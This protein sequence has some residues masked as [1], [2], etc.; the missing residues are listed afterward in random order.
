MPRIS[1]VVPVYN[2]E[3]YLQACLESIAAQTVSDLE[4]IVVDDGSTDSSA[5]IAGR[6]AEQDPRFRVVRQPNGGLGRARNAGAAL[7]TGELLAFVDSD[8]LLPP[9]AYELL[10]RSLERTGSDFA[11]GMVHRFDST[12]SRPAPFL[13]KAFI[14]P[15]RRTHV[16]R[17]RWL[18]ADRIA[19]NKLWRRSFWDEHEL[20]FPEGVTHEDIPLVV[21]AHFLARSVDVLTQPVYLYRVRDDG[22]RSITQRRTELSVLN[23]RVTAVESVNEF[24]G[25]HGPPAAQRWYQESVVADDLRYHLD[26]L[27]QGDDAYRRAFLDR[28][29]EFLELAEPGIEDPLPAIQRLKWHLVRRRL[30]PELL[31]VLRFQQNEFLDRPKVRIGARMYGDYP[32]LDDSLGIPRA[33]YRLDTT[34]RR[35]RN[36]LTLLRP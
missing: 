18:L 5:T 26:V 34:R 8:D 30:M 2:V 35:L 14:R 17:S 11:T 25:R 12:G 3:A 7:A 29:N 9:K 23:D 36:A 1:V 31:E 6:F 32:Y 33:I 16:T 19:H 20:R 24:L 10:S 4:V 22:V 21:P 27:D 28:A 15:R 13:E